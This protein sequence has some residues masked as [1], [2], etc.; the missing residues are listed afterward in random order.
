MYH[1][2]YKDNLADIR[3]KISKFSHEEAYEYYRLNFS[4]FAFAK[5]C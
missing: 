2:Y 3:A 1:A 4:V 5:S